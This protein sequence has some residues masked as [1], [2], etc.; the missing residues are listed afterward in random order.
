MAQKSLTRLGIRYVNKIDL[1]PEAVELDNYFNIAVDVPR[2]HG[3]TLGSFFIRV[4]SQ[5]A[6][7]P[8]RMVRS[9]ASVPDENYVV[10]LDID[11]IQEEVGVKAF[12]PQ[13]MDMIDALRTIEREVFE[14]SITEELRR[15]FDDASEQAL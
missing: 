5:Y 7:R 10:A 8:I 1:G 4:E 3:F 6:G 11:V 13:L 9:F 14:A 15:T 12:S 2:E